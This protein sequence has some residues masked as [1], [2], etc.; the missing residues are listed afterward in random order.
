MYITSLIMI[1]KFIMVTK[2]SFNY[3]FQSIFNTSI[4]CK[5][6]YRYFLFEY[7][8]NITLLESYQTL[9]SFN[10]FKYFCNLII[11]PTIII[12]KL[13]NLYIF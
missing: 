13:L 1:I 11:S 9:L 8:S 4:L 2:I 3:L 7:F 5:F 12:S 6:S 10:T